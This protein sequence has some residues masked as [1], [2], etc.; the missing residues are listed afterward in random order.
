MA[1][2]TYYF[3]NGRGGLTAVLCDAD[4]DGNLSHF[5]EKGKVVV[6]KDGE[7]VH[8]CSGAKQASEPADGVF[9]LEG[10][11][12]K[13]FAAEEKKEAAE[14]EKHAAKLEKEAATGKKS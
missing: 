12:G 9:V 5:D 1:K 4:E 3:D 6:D 7:P 8:F 14:E 11:A 10:T 13:K 2:G